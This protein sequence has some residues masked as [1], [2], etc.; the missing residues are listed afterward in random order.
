MQSHPWPGN[1]RQLLNVMRNVVVLNGRLGHARDAAPRPDRE[2]LARRSAGGLP[3]PG[4]NPDADTLLGLPLAEAERRLIEAT[5]ALHGGSIPKAARVLDVSPSTLY[6]KIDAWGALR[7]RSDEL[8]ADQPFFQPVAGIE[9]QPVADAVVR[10]H[11]DADHIAH[12][13]PA[14]GIRHH[15]PLLGSSTSKRTTAVRGSSAPRQR[16]GRKADIA[17]SASTSD[18]IGRIGPWAE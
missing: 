18:P 11:L 1:V 3:P 4:P 9:Q 7:R 6:R 12:R 13:G 5:L 2:N 16:R 14:V 10:P 15:R 8:L 17:V